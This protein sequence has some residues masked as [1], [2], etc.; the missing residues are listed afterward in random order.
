MSSE[1]HI[2]HAALDE[3]MAPAAPVPE[4]KARRSALEDISIARRRALAL[5]YSG[6]LS[7]A[8]DS[9]SDLVDADAGFRELFSLPPSEVLT[10]ALIVDQIHTEDRPRVVEALEKTVKTGEP[11]DERFRIGGDESP[12]WIRGIGEVHRQANDDGD[13]IVVG[14]NMDIS[15]EMQAES[16]L[17]A[18]VGEMRHRI[19]NSLAMVNSLA[20]ATA[21]ESDVIDDFVE[22][23]RG[24]ID[25]LAA[26]QRAIGATG[27]TH[28]VDLRTAI[29]GAMEPFLAT[30]DW[31]RRISVEVDEAGIAPSLG[32]ALALA[33]YELATN[34]IKYG[35]LLYDEG[36]IDLRC[37]TNFD[38]QILTVTWAEAHGGKQI[39]LPAV[40]SGFGTKLIDRLI[41][42]EDGIIERSATENSYHVRLSFPLRADD[43]AC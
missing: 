27:D 39:E 6:I 12:R 32:Q 18:I 5:H 1:N 11:Y 9:N 24:R 10:S 38:A 30:S 2:T 37:E 29:N 3:D 4:D 15:T 40:G 31:N 41:R 17:V 22:K 34:A 16:R 28:L 26:A 43:G 20:A 23:F 19:K 7:W 25:A 35:A 8:W 21:R 36:R 42:A 13:V 33:I 14:V